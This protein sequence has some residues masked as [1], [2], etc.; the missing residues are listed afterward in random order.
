MATSA[1]HV[2]RHP[3]DIGRSHTQRSPFRLWVAPVP[4]VSFAALCTYVDTFAEGG[5][6]TSGDD[7]RRLRQEIE[8]AQD[9]L[10]RPE[11]PGDEESSDS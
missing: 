5:P 2:I 4:A 3:L 6:D 9:A 8:Y 11:T 1:R 7:P 10:T